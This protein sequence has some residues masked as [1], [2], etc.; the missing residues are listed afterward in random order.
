MRVRQGDVGKGEREIE[1]DI[2]KGDEKERKKLREWRRKI[3]ND[4]ER[5]KMKD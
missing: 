1:G 5:Q 2:R 3:E 4:E